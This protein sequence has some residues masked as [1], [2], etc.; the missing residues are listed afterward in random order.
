MTKYILI[1]FFEELIKSTTV[2]FKTIPLMSYE[3]NLNW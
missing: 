2:T 3:L 1:A